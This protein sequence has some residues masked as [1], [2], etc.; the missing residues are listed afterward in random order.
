MSFSNRALAHL[1]AES[2]NADLD[3]VASLRRFLESEGFTDFMAREMRNPFDPDFDAAL[4]IYNG[5]Q[6]LR[7]IYMDRRDVLFDIGMKKARRASVPIRWTDLGQHASGPSKRIIEDLADFGMR[8]GIVMVHREVDREPVFVSVAGDVAKEL[9]RDDILMVQLLCSHFLTLWLAKNPSSISEIEELSPREVE[10]LAAS[11][12]GV[13]GQ[14]L[15]NLLKISEHTMRSH[16]RNIRTK[17]GA[18]S[19]PHAVQIAIRFGM[20]DA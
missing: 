1:H 8:D 20:L 2:L 9:S 10:I 14:N 11:S 18:R 15:Q 3:P 12:A 5:P 16:L 7:D 17:L 13:N 6:E 19:M 4:E